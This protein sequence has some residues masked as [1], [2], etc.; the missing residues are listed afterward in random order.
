MTNYKQVELYQNRA[1][2]FARIG[3]GGMMIPHGISKLQ[4]ALSG[5]EIIFPDPLGIGSPLSLYLT[6]FAELL[7]AILVVVGWKTQWASV[8]LVITMMV[9]AFIIHA[10]DPWGRKEFALLYLIGYIVILFQGGGKFSLDQYLSN[11]KKR[12]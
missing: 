7:C 9:A 12:K 8:P 10:D 3:F 11:R 5:A 6:I 4:D 2:L 1:K